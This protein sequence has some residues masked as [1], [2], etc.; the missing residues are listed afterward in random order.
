MFPT[1]CFGQVKTLRGRDN[2]AASKSTGVEEENGETEKV[3]WPTTSDGSICVDAGVLDINRFKTSNPSYSF[4]RKIYDRNHSHLIVIFTEM[5]VAAVCNTTIYDMS[6]L[7]SVCIMVRSA[8][9]VL[10]AVDTLEVTTCWRINYIRYQIHSKI[11]HKHC[12]CSFI[13]KYNNK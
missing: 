12:V 11:D 5:Y 7:T 6:T 13:Q 2:V 4:K 10:T 8:A 1:V 9:S 3:T